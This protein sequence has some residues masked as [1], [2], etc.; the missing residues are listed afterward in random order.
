MKANNK[1]TQ[2]KQDVLAYIQSLE[3]E[4]QQKESMTLIE[5]LTRI[6]GHPPKMWG[7]TIIGFDKYTYIYKTGREGE[8]LKIGF[9]PRKGKMSIYLMTGAENHK[10]DLDRMGPYKTGKSCLYIKTLNTIDLS[11]LEKV[12]TDS[13]TKMKDV[14]DYR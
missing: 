1:T 2:T 6:T 4:Q 5:L 8:H 7:S 14:M 12:C 10:E 11:I 13:Y 3:S 9:A